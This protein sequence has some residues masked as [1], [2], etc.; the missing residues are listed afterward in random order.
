M[1]CPFCNEN[2]KKENCISFETELYKLCENCFNPIV[3][4]NDKII[5]ITTVENKQKLVNDTRFFKIMKWIDD[6]INNIESLK[7]IMSNGETALSIHLLP[8]KP[9]DALLA[10]F[11][12]Q[13]VCGVFVIS[14][15]QLEVLSGRRAIDE[16]FE[17]DL[18]EVIGAV[19]EFI[20]QRKPLIYKYFE[21]DMGFHNLKVDLIDFELNKVMD[22]E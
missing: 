8:Y 16:T 22:N 5:P 18:D 12:I 9:E 6:N 1:N 11:D 10:A 21:L 15:K 13:D 2:I 14:Y 19:K 20:V 7:V 17:G 4:S 3:F